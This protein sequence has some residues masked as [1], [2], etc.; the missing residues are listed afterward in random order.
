MLL[1][2]IIGFMRLNFRTF[3]NYYN[4]NW[5]FPHRPST[6]KFGI[7]FSQNAFQN[8]FFIQYFTCFLSLLPV[9]DMQ[10]IFYLY[11]FILKKSISQQQDTMLEIIIHDIINIQKTIRVQI[12]PLSYFENT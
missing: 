7:H 12:L 6:Q 5:K 1:D 3:Y 10:F 2:F 11:K 9:A 8:Y 4:K